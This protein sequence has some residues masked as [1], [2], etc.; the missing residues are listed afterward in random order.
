MLWLPAEDLPSQLSYWPDPTFSEHVLWLEFRFCPFLGSGWEKSNLMKSFPFIHFHDFFQMVQKSIRGPVFISGLFFICLIHI[1]LS[2]YCI[3]SDTAN[4][5]MCMYVS[6][7]GAAVCVDDNQCWITREIFSSKFQTK[8]LYPFSGKSVFCCVCRIKADDIMMAFN[9][10]L[11]LGD[12]ISSSIASDRSPPVLKYWAIWLG[13]EPISP[14]SPKKF[15]QD[16]HIRNNFIENMDF[17]LQKQ[18]SQI[19]GFGQPCCGSVLIWNLKVDICN[20]H[21]NNVL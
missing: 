9:I 11:L 17:F 16:F 4:D 6:R 19:L 14:Y 2:F 21:A 12:W 3:H 13:L 5:D 10:F 7:L 20:L 8:L 1:T 18:F 15:S